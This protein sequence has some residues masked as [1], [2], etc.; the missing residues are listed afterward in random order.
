[1]K[2]YALDETGGAIEDP[3]ANRYHVAGPTGGSRPPKSLG[4]VSLRS[5][6]QLLT[7]LPVGSRH[8]VASDQIW[9]R[10]L[11]WRHIFS[12]AI[13]TKSMACMVGDRFRRRK[14]LGRS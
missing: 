6:D 9:T 11:L 4:H 10:F 13:Q 2:R 1:M 14:S 5:K 8:L 3:Y 7:T 12:A